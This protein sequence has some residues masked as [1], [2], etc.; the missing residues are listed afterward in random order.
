MTLLPAILPEGQG[1]TCLFA[2]VFVLLLHLAFP[3]LASTPDAILAYNSGIN[4]TNAGEYGKSLAAFNQATTLDPRYYEAWNE[5]ADVLNRL[6]RYNE[7]IQ[8]VDTALAINSSYVKGWINRGAILYNMGRYEEEL[9]SYD[10]AIAVDPT[11]DVAWFN[12]AYSLAALGRYEE[13][14]AAFQKVQELN[15]DYPYLQDNMNNAIALG[16][17]ERAKESSA[18]TANV[19]VPCAVALIV[20][21]VLIGGYLWHREKIQSARNTKTR[22]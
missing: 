17:A 22:K 14:L 8:A 11:S 3:A 18:G 19:V 6:G 15:P 7:S 4:S 13:S 12:R 21:I 2:V 10:K 5:K 1:R 20:A 9:A 16:Q